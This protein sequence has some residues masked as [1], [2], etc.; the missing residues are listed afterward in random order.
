M[1]GAF[2]AIAERLVVRYFNDVIM[3]STLFTLFCLHHG[4]YCLTK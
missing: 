3:Y 2:S 4:V 1:H